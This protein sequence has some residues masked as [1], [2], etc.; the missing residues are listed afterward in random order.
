MEGGVEHGLDQLGIGQAAAQETEHGV[1]GAGEHGVEHE[2]GR[3]AA[4][5]AAIGQRSLDP[6]LQLLRQAEQAVGVALV[7]AQGRAQGFVVR[8]QAGHLPGQLGLHGPAGDAFELVQRAQARFGVQVGRH[9]LGGGQHALHGGSGQLFL[10]V[11][12]LVQAGLGDAHIG[13]HL[14]HRHQLEALG[15][16]QAVDGVQD[17]VLTRLQHGFAEGGLGAGRH[18]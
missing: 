7:G 15:G 17:G 10:A 1:A 8:G 5:Q 18:G 14:V 4:A 16:Q 6:L 3:Q 9:A 2:R 11:E 12:V 13:H